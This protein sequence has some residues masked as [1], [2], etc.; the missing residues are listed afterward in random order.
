M[1]S[2][3]PFAVQVTEMDLSYSRGALFINISEIFILS[4]KAGGG[5]REGGCAFHREAS[6]NALFDRNLMNNLKEKIDKCPGFAI[7]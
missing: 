3:S 1:D 6:R 4:P 5:R 2:F 7:E